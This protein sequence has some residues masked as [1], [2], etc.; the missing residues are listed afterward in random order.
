M[1]EVAR[2]V[3]ETGHSRIPVYEGTDDQIVGIIH[4]KDVLKWVLNGSHDEP[5]RNNLRPAHFVPQSKNLHDLLREMRINRSQIV[6][7]QDEFGGTAGIVSIEDIVEEVVGEIVDEY[8]D[9]EIKVI[10]DGSKLM[11]GGKMNIDDLNEEVGTKF[12]SEEFDTIGGFVF[13]LFGKQPA[14]GESIESGGYRFTVE[15]TD[16]R[17][18]NLIAL[19]KLEDEPIS[20]PMTSDQAI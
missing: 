4:A 13:G 9:D 14:P 11:I 10:R 8:D 1:A 17:R 19:E 5:L 16:G 2:V 15:D 3:E 6:I 18:I 12:E 20:F 7:V